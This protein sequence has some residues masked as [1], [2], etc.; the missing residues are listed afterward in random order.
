MGHSHLTGWYRDSVPV[1]GKGQ[2]KR[3]TRKLKEETD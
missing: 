1:I 3:K 2:R